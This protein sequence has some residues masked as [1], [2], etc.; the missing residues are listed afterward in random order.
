MMKIL[1]RVLL[2]GAFI[3]FIRVNTVSSQRNW[4]SGAASL[5]QMTGDLAGINQWRQSQKQT[6]M[7]A[8][9]ALPDSVKQQ[10]IRQAAHYQKFDWPNLPA[11]TFLEFSQNGNRTRYEKI[12]RDRRQALSALT[13]GLLISGDTSYLPAMVNGIWAICEEST[14][15]YPAHLALQRKYTPFPN[16]GENILDLGNG[17]TSELMSWVYLLAGGYLDKVSRVLS[18]RMYFELEKR[19]MEPY[20]TRSD[21]WWMGFK[22]Q[23]VNNWNPFVNKSVL[24]TSLLVEKNQGRLDSVVHKTMQS[25]D[26]FINQYPEDGGCD[27][28]PGYWSMAAGALIGYLSKLQSATQGKIDIADRPLIGKMGAFI[29][30]SNIA[31]HYFVNYGDAHATVTPNVS[32]LY[33]FG[34]S[35]KNDTL[36]QFAA[37]FAKEKGSP[38]HYLLS[39]SGGLENFVDDLMICQSLAQGAGSLPYIKQSWLPDLEQ[40]TVRAQA[41]SDEG[42]FLAAKGGT[43][44]ASHNHNDVGNFII[45]VDGQ[46]AIIDLGVGTYTKQTFSK[47]RY[48]IFTMQSAWHNLPVINGY[49]Q[50]EGKA[51]RAKDIQLVQ[52]KDGTT[53]AMDLADAYPK[54]AGV[55][56]WKRKIAFLGTAVELSE[57]YALNKYTAPSKLSLITPLT[58]TSGK[59]FLL[60]K[61]KKTGKGLKLSFNGRQLE[62]T[63]ETK[64]LSD[65]SLAHSWGEQVYRIQFKVRTDKL[66][67]QYK[68][69][70]TEL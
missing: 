37:W 52:G 61:D 54:E 63:V 53:L 47:E 14:W 42:L 7:E 24:L 70:F 20:L 55:R 5:D 64:A 67:G 45:Y 8:L 9:H 34:E 39:V 44:G 41:G 15:A 49:M 59:D 46:P 17:S 11:T 13:I 12:R 30:R 33:Q 48:Q 58:V 38:Y 23:S 68:I 62:P 36:K 6:V 60:L 3:L 51:Y 32:A 65:P 22:G 28:G 18:E 16:P 10:L 66:T 35:C 25:V 19:V 27:E 31:G 29:Y 40:L 1:M 21:F 2:M 4:L 56:F 69:R 50:K 57:S 43:N 26:H